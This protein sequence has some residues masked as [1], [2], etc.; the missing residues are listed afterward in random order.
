MSRNGI[1]NIAGSV[2]RTGIG[3]A[4]IR[5][6]VKYAGLEE[7]GVWTLA[8]SIAGLAALAESALNISATVSLA[9]ARG[10]ASEAGRNGTSEILTF[11][12]V[13]TILGATLLALV[14]FFGAD[15]ISTQFGKLT[16]GQQAEL[17]AAL[18]VGG[19]WVWSRLLQQ[20][21]LGVQQAYQ[22]YGPMNLLLTL[23]SAAAGLGLIELAQR[24]LHAPEFMRW[25]AC[26]S[27]GFLLIHSLYAA[28]LL[29]PAH[30]KLRW[31]SQAARETGTHLGWTCLSTLGT[32]LF[33]Q[34]D[35][36]VVGRL[37]GASAAG[38]YAAITS[39][40]MQINSLSAM[41]VQPLLTDVSRL[42]ADTAAPKL[43]RAFEANAI[44]ALALAVI[45]FAFAE[46]VLM[47]ILPGLPSSEYVFAFRLAMVIY[48][49][50]SLNATGYF[51]CLALNA[52]RATAA[53]V[54]CSA[55]LAISLIAVCATSWDLNGA[56]AGNAGYQLAWLLTVVGFRRADI[57]ARTWLGWL[58]RPLAAFSVGLVLCWLL[59]NDAWR[60]LAAGVS[61]VGMFGF[62]G[63]RMALLNKLWRVRCILKPG[64]ANFTL[65][66]G[67]NFVYP[68]DS[69]IGFSL[70]NGSFEST[71]LHF[72]QERLRPGNIFLDIGANGGVYT[73]L[74]AKR[75]GQ[76]GHVYAFEP[77]PRNLALLRQNVELNRLSNVT[78]VT[79][80]VSNTV[81]TAQFAISHDGAMNSLAKNEHAG[82]QIEKWET[83]PT[84]TLDA[85]LRELN[86]TRVDV[87][88]IDV[89]GAERLVLD[90]A[91]ET[92]SAHRE[93]TIL[94]ESANI[95]SRSFNYSARQILTDLK[96]LGFALSYFDGGNLTAAGNFD[97]PRLGRDV[98]NFVAARTPLV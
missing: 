93:V 53:I 38:I 75:V 84:T 64:L 50:Y 78:I 71:E 14:L 7:F 43:R 92:L 79:K 26:I 86:V 25:Q 89:E 48:A 22:R 91:R 62:S 60:V 18:R 80:A 28:M 67:S 1:Y 32:Q 35:R 66:D 5:Y 57:D 10:R 45:A 97:D 88:K 39:V 3:L 37:L 27:T 83:V 4:T 59:P 55:V 11:L 87:I 68:A 85:A 58:A 52:V 76:E 77:D 9:N 95:A 70:F 44:V 69:I 42:N 29:G 63:F 90:G 98:Y 30:L 21:P 8:C 82:Q 94:F 61:I 41:G 74:A 34:A 2:V 31:G 65:P 24:G 96:D 19:V 56:V 40:A 36:I 72:I 15:A 17:G 49:L 33:S 16:V 13:A 20:I 47:L 6:V 46:R 23:Q 12:G 81:G 73:V 51:L 54:L